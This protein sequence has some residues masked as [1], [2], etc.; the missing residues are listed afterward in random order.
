MK[1]IRDNLEFL[2]SKVCST[3]RAYHFKNFLLERDKVITW[4]DVEFCLNTP[5]MFDVELIDKMTANK[6]PLEQITKSWTRPVPEHRQI[7]ELFNQGNSAVVNNYGCYNNATK[8]LLRLFEETFNVNCNIHVYCGLDGSS[9]FKIH[10]DYPSNVIIQIDG[11]TLWR[12]YRNKVSQL[13]T[14]GQQPRE[15]ELEL[16]LEVVLEPGDALYVPARAFHAAIV[17]E[18]RLSISV[19]CWPRQDLT[20]TMRSD[21]T[22]YKINHWR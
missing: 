1:Q 8:D 7:L 10:E 2:K 14:L 18:K 21:R 5:S 16:D 3:D 4:N 22:H 17:T 12:V 20:P 13:L 11:K 9:S 6:I 19:P 15:D